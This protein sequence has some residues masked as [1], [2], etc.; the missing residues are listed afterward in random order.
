MK[1]SI[2]LLLIYFLSGSVVLPEESWID[3]DA[4][5]ADTLI[6]SADER[7]RIEESIRAVLDF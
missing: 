3:S 6:I 2:G 7:E 1:I 5:V 4:A